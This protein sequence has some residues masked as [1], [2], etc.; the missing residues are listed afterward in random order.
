M[1]KLCGA[2][3]VTCNEGN[4][5][6]QLD[7]A[8]LKSL[9]S[10]DRLSGAF[11]YENEFTFAPSHKLVIA[12]NAKPVLE[13]DAAARRR[14]HLVP[15]NV[16]FKG[17]ENRQLEEQL[18]AEASA[19]LGLLIQSCMEWQRIGLAPPP[20]VTEATKELFRD[21]DPI[22]RFAE[23]RLEPDPEGFEFTAD[24]VKAYQ[25]FLRD[26]EEPVVHVDERQLVREIA[27]R[28]YKKGK[29]RNERGQELRGLRGVRIKGPQGPKDQ[30]N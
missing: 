15:F 2:R 29:K 21:L 23:E 28:G 1:A 6:V 16:S 12:T 20:S 27:E 7:M 25:S 3:L 11:L 4:H 18:K 22:G 30:D 9:A 10:S 24:I 8:L 14:V 26:N 13:T 5:N 17:R 19:I